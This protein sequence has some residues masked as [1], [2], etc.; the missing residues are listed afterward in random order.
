M[1]ALAGC[2]RSDLHGDTFELHTALRCKRIAALRKLGE[3]ER[4]SIEKCLSKEFIPRS[5]LTRDAFMET[6]ISQVLEINR[7][8]VWRELQNLGL[9]PKQ[10]EELHGIEPDSLNSHFASVTTT[11]ARVSEECTSQ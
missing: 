4:K 6:K 5:A 9:L 1:G 7:N 8:G 10:Q 2:D 3:A 11:D